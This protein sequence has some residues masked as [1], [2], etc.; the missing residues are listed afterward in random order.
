MYRIASAVIKVNNL[1]NEIFFKT[2][3]IIFYYYASH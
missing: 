2:I 1:K 3:V